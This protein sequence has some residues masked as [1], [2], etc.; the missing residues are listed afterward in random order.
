[1]Y[2]SQTD[3]FLVTVEP[4]FLPEHSDFNQGVFVFSYHVKI[5]NQSAHKAQLLRRKWIIRDGAGR[6]RE[7]DGQGVVGE[8][9]WILP[10]EA[11]EYSSFCP[12]S[13]QTGSMRGAYFLMTDEPEATEIRVEIP[14]FFLRVDSNE[15]FLHEAPTLDA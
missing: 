9:P 14:L 2:S 15:P 12:L 5:F 3:Q 4:Q 8:Q 1:M 10:G 6:T 7:V 11:F 13:T